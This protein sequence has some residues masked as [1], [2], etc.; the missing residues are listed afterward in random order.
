[1]SPS[2]A[3]RIAE[4]VRSGRSTAESHAERALAAIAAREHSVHAFLHRRETDAVLAD[5]RRVDARPAAERGPL[6]G[7]PVLIK[8]NLCTLDMPTT[9]GS[10]ILE[11][12]RAPY[13]ATVVRLLREAGAVLMGKANLDEFAMGSSTENS[14]YGATRN[15]WDL[16]RVPGGSSGGSAAAVAAGMVP[17]A[18]GSDTGGSVRQPAAL[19][20]VTGLKPSYGR[21]SR[22]GLVAFASSLDQVGPITRTAEDA[23]LV[24]SVIA[25]PD[26][27]D[28]TC[29]DSEFS[30]DPALLAAG[31]KGQKIG[32]PENWIREG[33]HPEVLD[34]FEA[35]LE[36]LCR[37]GAVRVPVEL[38]DPAYS[39]CTYYLV[40]PAEASSN[41]ARFDGVRYGLRTTGADLLG[42]YGGTRR[43]GFGPEVRRRIMIGTYALSAGYYDAYYLKAQQVRTRIREDY[44][45]AFSQVD[46]LAMPTTPTPAFRLGEKLDDPLS[47]YLND[48][49]TLSVNLAGLPGVSI[50]CGHTGAGLPVGMQLLAAQG[51]DGLVLRIS[52][53]YQGLTDH[54]AKSPAGMEDEA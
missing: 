40:A 26:P 43:Q 42:M 54:H 2:T 48:V 22:Y 19:C 10:R 24:L 53:A 49:F 20:G 5:A 34:R 44:A 17:V 6:A 38:M 4:E 25:R 46:V 33:V 32:V 51:S 15:P 9:C 18:L 12:Y 14:A 1:M 52:H 35:A 29:G 16:E 27:A 11:G 50:P 31:V 30:L 28:S 41:L 3:V 8:D 39:L 45:R 37:A 7:V 47:M 36:T 21:V 13:E 23:A